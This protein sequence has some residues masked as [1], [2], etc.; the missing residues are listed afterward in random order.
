[1]SGTTD[2]GHNAL[3]GFLYQILGAGDMFAETLDPQRTTPDG[4]IETLIGFEHEKDGEDVILEGF[5]A[6]GRHKRELVQFKY[7]ADPVAYPIQ[8]SELV[9]IAEEML[10]CSKLANKSKQIP[11]G[12]VL[13]SNRPLSPMSPQFLSDIMDDK[14]HGAVDWVSY[15]KGRARKKNKRPNQVKLRSILKQLRIRQV[16]AN[17]M[18]AGLK[19]H[20]AKFGVLNGAEFDAGA[21][22]LISLLIQ[23][24]AAAVDRHITIAEFDEALASYPDPKSLKFVDVLPELTNSLQ[25]MKVKLD[26]SAT[27]KLVSRQA[28]RGLAA[29][30][31]DALIVIYGD[32]GCGKSVAAFQILEE[33]LTDRNGTPQA[34]AAATRAY[35][36]KR[37][38]FGELVS[39]WRN[40]DEKPNKSDMP[41]RALLRIMTANPG[42][43]PPILFLAIDG[44]DELQEESDSREWVTLMVDFFCDEQ[45]KVKEHGDKPRAVL[46]VTCRETEDF[47][48][49]SPRSGDFGDQIR[50]YKSISIDVFTTDE[51]V[52]L[53]RRTLEP[54]LA[55]RIEAA[56]ASRELLGPIPTSQGVPSIDLARTGAK[57]DLISTEVLKLIE[58]PILWRF[59]ENLSHTEQTLFLDG[60]LPTIGSV[61]EDYARLVCRRASKRKHRFRVDDA[62]EMLRETAI[63]FGDPGGTGTRGDWDEVA[64]K[65]NGW[66]QYRARHF[67]AEA[68][69]AGLIK[70]E[71]KQ[72][73]WSWCHPIMCKL[74]KETSTSTA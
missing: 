48:I 74:L 73:D 8:P 69:S 6:G 40:P 1:M 28:V 14:P 39:E 54:H 58:W 50:L 59:F 20:A 64:S 42:A 65:V 70:S 44:L 18:I 62:L 4:G 57:A 46:V 35:G 72:G 7:S 47:N 3:A 37:F 25:K 33:A 17:Q 45:L 23:K 68:K 5:T 22:N 61:V 26:F 12:Y 60:D 66:P 31:E 38:S 13:A 15:G 9:K 41:E 63:N 11:T 30:P 10:R 55:N 56:L 71:S 16:D 2:G 52:D 67:F 19:K 32:G 24:G 34:L 43:R 53:S 27:T 49:V 51:L 36:G 29:S 21:K